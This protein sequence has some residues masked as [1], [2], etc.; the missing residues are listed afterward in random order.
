M[1]YYVYDISGDPTGIVKHLDYQTEFDGFQDAKKFARARRAELGEGS[2]VIVK[3]IF[4]GSKLEA[5]E[6]LMEKR[7]KPI[8]M[9]WEK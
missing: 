1:P 6:R 9:E 8:V 5:E 7:E 4:A 3:V 2:E